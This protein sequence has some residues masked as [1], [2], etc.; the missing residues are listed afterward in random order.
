MINHW[1]EV[2]RGQAYWHSGRVQASPSPAPRQV[3]CVAA[4]AAGVERLLVF[5][6][7]CLVSTRLGWRRSRYLPRPTSARGLHRARLI[8]R[9]RLRDRRHSVPTAATNTSLHRSAGGSTPSGVAIKLP[10]R[11]PPKAAFAGWHLHPPRE[12]NACGGPGVERSRAAGAFPD[13]APPSQSRS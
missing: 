1:P 9:A 5:R 13:R 7:F 6:A 3:G 11:V 4:R 12:R 10:R 8:R 2:D